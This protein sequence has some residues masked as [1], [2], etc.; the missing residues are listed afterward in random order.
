MAEDSLID[1][2]IDSAAGWAKTCIAEWADA[3]AAT[4]KKLDDKQYTPTDLVDDVAASVTRLCKQA[5][6]GF[7][8]AAKNAA[9]AR[10]RRP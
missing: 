3:A 8:T 1:E 5:T 2:V 4:A 6:A 9:R 7:D 10:G